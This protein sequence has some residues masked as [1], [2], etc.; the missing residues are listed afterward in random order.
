MAASSPM[1]VPRTKLGRGGL[2]RG[3][4]TEKH[5][6]CC[7]DDEEQ[8]PRRQAPHPSPREGKA[9]PG[10]APHA[11][12]FPAAPKVPAVFLAVVCTPPCRASRC[13]ICM[14]DSACAPLVDSTSV[15]VRV[16]KPPTLATGA[17]TCMC[18]HPLVLPAGF[19]GDHPRSLLGGSPNTVEDPSQT[20]PSMPSI[21][22]FLVS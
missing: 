20:L 10:S 3:E 22:D 21:L 4:L 14:G 19:L 5:E 18:P 12:H 11:P 1:T 8:N 2:G 9:G 13:T 17:A 6:A 7:S 16:R 15:P